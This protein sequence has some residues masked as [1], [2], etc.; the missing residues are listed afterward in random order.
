MENK[1]KKKDGFLYVENSRRTF[2][3]TDFFPE[4]HIIWTV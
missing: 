2:K 1:M 4:R 3:I